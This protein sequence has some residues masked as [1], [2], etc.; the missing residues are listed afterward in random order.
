[1]PVPPRTEDLLQG[2]QR[3]E[4]ILRVLAHLAEPLRSDPSKLPMI[5][6]NIQDGCFNAIC[7]RFKDVAT[8]LSV[9]QE[10]HL[11]QGEPSGF[12]QVVIFLVRFLQF[13]LGLR[14]VWTNNAKS[15]AGGLAATLFGLAMVCHA[16]SGSFCWVTRADFVPLLDVWRWAP[17]RY[18]HISI[19]RRYPLLSS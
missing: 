5:E 4:E 13:D 12:S 10:T 11:A 17:S 15:A 6:P 14:G 1:V 3:A 7:I 8:M 9:D 18:H 16:H 2:I 19:T